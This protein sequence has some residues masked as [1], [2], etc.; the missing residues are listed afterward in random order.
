[1]KQKLLSWLDA[2]IKAA[3]SEAKRKGVTFYDR[4]YRRGR[5]NALMQLRAMLLRGDFD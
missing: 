1:L 2:E 4:A 3:R 5:F